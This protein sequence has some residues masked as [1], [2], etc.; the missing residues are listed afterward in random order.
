MQVHV[1]IEKN[2]ILSAYIMQRLFYGPA[3]AQIKGVFPYDDL[4]GVFL[5]SRLCLLKGT[6]GRAVIHHYEFPGAAE[7]IEC[8]GCLL[9]T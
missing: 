9:N 8:L 7:I 5:S 4:P 6:V 1:G 2:G 3:L